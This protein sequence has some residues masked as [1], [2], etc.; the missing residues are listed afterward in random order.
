[1]KQIN[2]NKIS[3]TIK[4]ILTEIGG[5]YEGHLPLSQKI[6]GVS[7]IEENT[8]DKLTFAEDKTHIKKASEKA[9]GVVIVSEKSDCS[10][11]KSRIKVE[12]VRLSYA[13]AAKLFR[14]I[15]YY[16]P[17]IA[18]SAEIKEN[19]KIGKN[20]SINSNTY[21]GRN[22]K[23]GDNVVIAPGVT[24]SENVSIGK[25]TIVHPNVVIESE[26][27]IGKDVIIEA[28]T[29]IGSEG[30]GYVST[31]NKHYHIPQLG[32]VIIEDEVEI[33][34]NVSIDRGTQ[35]ATVVGAGTKIDN[36]VQ[37][38]HNVKV[39][40]NCLIVAQC[41][42]AGSTIIGDNVIIA[43]SVGIIDHVKIGDNVKIGAASVVT[44]DIPEDSFYL[45]N[46]AQDRM[47]EL[48]TRAIRN[49]LP[50][51]RKGLKDLKR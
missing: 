3:Y 17:G 47:K 40:K 29:V 30:Y 33:G 8:E 6:V 39:G 1:M 18:E 19:V 37:I 46:P 34:S 50:D 24:I 23:I 2:K 43:G 36:L 48:R 10:N 32:N 14:P 20:V 51:Y 41:G 26:S 38:A 5:N 42:I 9:D 31:E 15:P 11:I 27:V 21:I 12:N 7:S 45:G 4:E 35:T 49:K 13:K 16:K 25:N 44:S 22:C 28:Q